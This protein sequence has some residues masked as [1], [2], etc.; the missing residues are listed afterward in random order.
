MNN[1]KHQK[2]VQLESTE[3]FCKR[4][5]IRRVKEKGG[6]EFAWNGPA[7]QGSQ[8]SSEICFSDEQDEFD[9]LPG[10]FKEH[11]WK[12]FQHKAGLGP[13]PGKYRG[14]A[15]DPDDIPL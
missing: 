13:N 14:P 6:R 12:A 7:Y 10:E 11:L 8:E 9:A 5:G 2:K 15:V 4:L 1:E 3:E